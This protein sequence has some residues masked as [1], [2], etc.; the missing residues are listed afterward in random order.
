MGS[1]CR[2]PLRPGCP[3]LLPQ[4]HSRK[5]KALIEIH[6]TPAPDPWTSCTPESVRGCYQA[7]QYGSRSSTFTAHGCE[8]DFSNVP[9]SWA[10][11]QSALANHVRVRHQ[12][13]FAPF[14]ELV[15]TGEPGNEATVSGRG[16]VRDH[17]AGPRHRSHR[18]CPH[19]HALGRLNWPMPL[20]RL[21]ETGLS[22]CPSGRTSGY[23]HC[24]SRPRRSLPSVSRP[25]PQG[26][27]N[28]P[29]PLPK[30][31]NWPR[32]FPSSVNF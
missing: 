7:L 9:W 8:N 17:S 13:L 14:R 29:G 3:F 15:I 20:A 1:P 19:S 23:G 16:P 22:H 12:F 27:F 24:A 10:I 28:C 18:L 4:S 25:S 11:S 21:S 6:P 5:P 30:L 26:I 32:Y 2:S 31:P